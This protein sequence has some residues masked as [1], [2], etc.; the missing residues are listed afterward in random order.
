MVLRCPNNGVGFSVIYKTFFLLVLPLPTTFCLLNQV[1]IGR[2]DPRVGPETSHRERGFVKKESDKQTSLGETPVIVS[3]LGPRRY[4]D[5]WLVGW[6][7]KLIIN[8]L[9]EVTRGD[10]YTSKQDHLPLLVI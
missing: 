5:N 2:G 4:F 3:S 9:R 6:V 10:G 8:D 1:G 7:K